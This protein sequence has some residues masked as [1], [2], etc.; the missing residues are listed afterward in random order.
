MS[1][2]L[3]RQIYFCMVT[4]YS[5]TLGYYIN[6]EV[7]IRIRKI[8][9]RMSSKSMFYAD[10]SLEV[11]EIFSNPSRF[12]RLYF[13]NDP[14]MTTFTTDFMF[15]STGAQT[16]VDVT[17][18]VKVSSSVTYISSVL[19]YIISRSSLCKHTN[20]CMFVLASSMLWGRL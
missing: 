16:C 12:S 17:V 7:M 1:D 8:A 14:A 4:I 18:F 10:A 11:T 2:Q 6:C 9:I 20:R 15:R 5:S 3:S 19:A 13:Q